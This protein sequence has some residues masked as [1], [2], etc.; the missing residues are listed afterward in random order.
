[1]TTSD[2]AK[3]HLERP[4]NNNLTINE[5]KAVKELKSLDNVIIKPADKGGNIVLLNRDMYIDMCM[6]HLSDVSNYSVLPSDPTEM[7]IKDF[8]ALLTIALEQKIINMEEFKYLLPHKHPTVAT[9]YCL[10]KVHK[11][12]TTPPGRPII[13]GNNCLTERASKFVNEILH[14]YI[15]DLPSYIQDTKSTLLILEGLQVPPYT[16]L[17]SLDVVQ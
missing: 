3:M 1:M 10:P 16:L 13:S 2:L 17:A 15:T 12:V 4:L 5:R 9:L 14:P 8:E 6:A 7:Y 11:S